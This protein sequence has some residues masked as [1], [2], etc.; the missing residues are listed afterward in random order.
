MPQ[1]L[2][3]PPS[4]PAR[5]V[6]LA[7]GTGSLLGSLIEAAAGDYPARIVAV[8]VDRACPATEV[9]A[10]ASLPVFTV[11]LGDHPDRAAWDKAITEATAAHSPDLIVSAGF[12]KILG[13]QFLSRFCGRTLNTHPALLPAFAGAHAVPDALA[14]GVKVTGCTVHLVD[15]GMD[16]GPILAQEPIPVLDGDT[17]ETLHERI[18]VVERRLLVDVVA[19][20][21]TRGVTWTGRKATLG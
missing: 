20:L 6:V 16:T 17:E 9:A 3:V 8:G 11:R 13:P 21:A 1:P 15:A 12:M 14:Y 19:A 7:S 4:A 18:K 5:V 2:Q 10:A